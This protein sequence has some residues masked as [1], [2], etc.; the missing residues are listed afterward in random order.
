M[1]C[2]MISTED[3]IYFQNAFHEAVEANALETVKHYIDVVD[4]NA[5]KR[6][7]SPLYIAAEKGYVAMAE[8]LL[9][10]GAN[11]RDSASPLHIAAENGHIPMADFFLKRGISVNHRDNQSHRTPLYKAVKNKKH[12]MVRFLLQE[13][14]GVDLPNLFGETPLHIATSL[15]D[16]SMVALLLQKGANV[17]AQTQSG[18]TPL[19]YAAS[20]GN[21]ELLKVLLNRPDAKTF[22]SA[23][24]F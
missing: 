18:A 14:A 3:K 2:Q 13:G 1:V 4:V 7:K 11:Y 15:G 22:E 16:V 17:N 24:A 5:L 20:I 21:V 6:N 23:D 10:K 12:E 19:H 9:S 8:L